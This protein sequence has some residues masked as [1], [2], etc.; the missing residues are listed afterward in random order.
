MVTTFQI[1]SLPEIREFLS[2]FANSH[3]WDPTMNQRLEAVSEE[4]SV[5]ITRNLEAI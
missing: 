4:T 2:K 5:V 3:G 1:E